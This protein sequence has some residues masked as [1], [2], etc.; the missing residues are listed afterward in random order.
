M[1]F[2]NVHI[3][4][5]INKTIDNKVFIKHQDESIKETSGHQASTAQ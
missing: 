2:N 3:E 1:C 5:C 4:Y